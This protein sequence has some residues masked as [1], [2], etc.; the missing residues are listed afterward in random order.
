MNAGT[1]PVLIMAGGTGGHVF[2]ALAVARELQRRG[3]PVVWMGTRAGLEARVVPEAGITIDW[4]DVGGLRGKGLWRRLRAPFMLVH[5]AWQALGIMRRR[6]PRS[7]LGMGGFV[8]GPG[9]LVA[10]LSGRRLCIHEQNAVPGLT[11]RVLARLTRCVMAA[12][13]GSLARASVVGN[14]VREDIAALPPPQQRMADREGSIR[15]LVIGG[16]LGALALN[17]CVPEALALLAPEI[18]PQVR[19]QCGERHVDVTRAA[20]ADAGVSADVTPFIE[21]MAAAY[22]W[23]DL[24]LCRAGALTVSELAAAGCAAILVPY[25]HAVDDHQTA[26]A[27]FLVDA[28]AAQLLP[29][30]RMD[31]PALAALLDQHRDRRRLLDMAMAARALARTDAA[32]RV[33]DACLEGMR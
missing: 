5:A 11:N 2:P 24:V 3:V 9:G 21:D 23:A 14:P 12:F 17:R 7:V 22:A 10:R 33:A 16:S 6:R 30:A 26:N 4:I 20:Y 25:P 28:G 27:R 29:Q 31:A 18:R 15:L 13:P 1:H 32:E 8:A 19:H